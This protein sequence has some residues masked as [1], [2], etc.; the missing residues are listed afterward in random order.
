M[1]VVKINKERFIFLVQ[2][3]QKYAL[4]ETSTKRKHK[5]LIIIGK[6]P[7]IQLITGLPIFPWLSPFPFSCVPSAWK[8][9]VSVVF[10][11]LHSRTAR[12]ARGGEKRQ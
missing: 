10:S 6:V 9:W 11:R 7:F 3:A 5:E 12:P 2:L 8:S 4:N 1:K